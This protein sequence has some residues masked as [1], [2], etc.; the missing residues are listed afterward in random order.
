M[1]LA[2]ECAAVLLTEP[3]HW[4]DLLR[5]HALGRMMDADV[6]ANLSSPEGRHDPHRCIDRGRSH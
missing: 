6:V 2:P 4:A 1:T 3:E 5:C